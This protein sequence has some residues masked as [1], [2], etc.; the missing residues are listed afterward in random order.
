M[1]NTN[2][3]LGLVNKQ[4][5]ARRGGTPVRAVRTKVRTKV[6]QMGR[7]PLYTRVASRT[8]ILLVY[9]FDLNL[10]LITREDR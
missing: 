6:R 4:W 3:T 5:S 10:P 8:N 1:S 2:G 7:H 9:I